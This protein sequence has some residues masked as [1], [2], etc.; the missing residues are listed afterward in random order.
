MVVQKRE[1]PKMALFTTTKNDSPINILAYRKC[2]VNSELK[3]WSK[4][5]FINVIIMYFKNIISSIN[6]YSKAVLRQ[7]ARKKLFF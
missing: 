5:Q 4:S 6:V 2:I 7:A 1:A 3:S